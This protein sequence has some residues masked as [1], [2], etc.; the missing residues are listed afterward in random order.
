[1]HSRIRTLLVVLY[2]LLM[3]GWL[4]NRLLGRDRLRLDRP[5]DASCWIE[6]RRQPDTTS[7]FSEA[8]C[9]EGD[10][11]PSAARPL[12]LLLRSIARLYAPAVP[13]AHARTVYT[14]SA[15][16]EQRIQDEVYTLW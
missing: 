12:M 10:D 11:E 9:C 2:P 4:V 14:S 3:L 8:S 7:Y 13:D 1:M 16:R 6:R 15:D 5:A